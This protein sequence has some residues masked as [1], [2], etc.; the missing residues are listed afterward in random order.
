VKPRPDVP[1]AARCRGRAAGHVAAAL[2]VTGT[3]AGCAPATAPQSWLAEITAI[4]NPATAGSRYPRLAAAPD[5]T[6]VMS[7]L[8]PEPD[9]GHAL[10]YAYWSEGGFGAA[11][12]VASGEDWFV[13]WADFPS[14][15]PGDD[16]LLAAHWLRKLPGHAYAYEVRL[17]IS[18]DRGRQWSE[19]A[20]PHDD[21]TATEHGFVSLLPQ[22]GGVLAAWLDGR[23][24]S[25]GH[26]HASGS[27]AMTLRALSLAR[28]GGAAGTGV[29]LDARVCDC[30]QTG[31]ALATDGPVI[32]YRD[33][34]AS[35]VRDIALVRW[36]DRGWSEPVRVHADGWR[37]PACP[38]NG[39]AVAARGA[40][41]AVAWF[42][43]PDRP[44]V[45]L[46]FS[47]D[48]GANFGAPLEVAAGA[49]LGRVDLVLL[50]DGRAVVSWL[51]AGTSGARV[52][53]QPWT[54]DGAA[55]EARVVTPS[56][57]ARSTGFLQ[58][59]LA[60]DDLLFAWTDDGNPSA[61]RTA[62]ARLN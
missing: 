44:R 59:A 27:G 23:H 32:V 57:G 13:N 8:A 35:E 1:S 51:E 40:Q 30:C 11:A 36:T 42:T 19:P 17:A 45:R 34:D 55:G 50:A 28:D 31:A 58:L 25:G 29:E 24:T 3:L 6:V 9:G 56:T 22:D 16:G 60:G 61:V 20:T 15:V 10:R 7:W 48:G 33:R 21:G 47:G 12:T 18:A 37:M 52:L 43:A 5:G 4:A 39:P 38:V 14:V 46:A 41:V 62:K 53:V 2:A 26:D 54:Q 49:P